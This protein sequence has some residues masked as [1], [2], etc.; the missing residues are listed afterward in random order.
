M[1]LVEVVVLDEHSFTVE[2][3]PAVL[4][5]I[6]K[7]LGLAPSMYSPLPSLGRFNNIYLLGDDFVLRVPPEHTT[8]YCCHAY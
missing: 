2:V 1:L 6:A 4:A 7:R 3:A 8:W 5:A